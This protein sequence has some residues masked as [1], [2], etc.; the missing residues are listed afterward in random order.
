MGKHTHMEI[1]P[2]EKNAK[3]HP[4]KQI[5]LI[6]SSIR[7]F[8]WQQ[9]IKVG[10]NGVIIAGHGRWSAYQE[11]KEKFNLPEPWIIDENGNTLSG[12]A[13][14]RKLT[15]LEERDYRIRDNRIAESDWD[16]ELLIGELRELDDED[17]DISLK[18]FKKDLL[19]SKDEREDD[20][21]E[22][23]PTPKSKTGDLYEIGDHRILCGDSTKPE[24]I[25]RMMNGSKAD[26]VFT[27]PP[28]GV[29]YVGKTKDA[30][31]IKNDSLGSNG[32]MELLRD[33]FKALPLKLGGVFYVCTTPGDMETW[34]RM[35]LE[36]VN[37]TIHQGITW[38]KNSMVL[39]HSDYHYQ[40][41]TILYGW[42]T[43]AKHD[44]YGDRTMKTVWKEEPDDDKLLKWAR[45]VMQKSSNGK[46]TVWRI[47]RPSRSTDHPTMKPVNLIQRALINSSKQEDIIA[48]PF[49][50]SGST[51]IACEK[52][53]RVCYG[54]EI[55]PKYIDVIIQRYVDYTGITKVKKNGEEEEWQISEGV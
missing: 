22:I 3:K 26:M 13:E 18:G 35:A 41:E 6:A 11:Y 2:Y 51:L 45:S 16:Q 46:T 33:S 53:G 48:D 1:R 43:G 15:N 55:D 37:F 20:M 23:P 29:E 32:T 8:G 52:L 17:L 44:F 34:F 39:G 38:I 36:S 14:K 30:L 10:E 27:D 42:I 49:L 12:E 31:T 47:D 28:Y 24:D 5:E 7:D 50:G 9:P 40:H 19:V 25:D 4:P 21:P 54:M